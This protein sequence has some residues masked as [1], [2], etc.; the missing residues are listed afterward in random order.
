MTCRGT[1]RKGTPC[2]REATHGEWCYAHSPDTRD[3]AS[4]T[5]RRGHAGMMRRMSGDSRPSP[6]AG[7]LE[8]VRTR[9]DAAQRLADIGLAVL[10]GQLDRH[11]ANAASFALNNA[12]KG[13]PSAVVADAL[14]EA[15]E[16]IPYDAEEL[17]RLEAQL[18]RG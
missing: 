16:E 4:E 10:S 11:E 8:P 2:Q 14:S 6:L 13:L 1:T 15:L 18:R 9:E 5:Q 3:E 17:S 12:M 7:L